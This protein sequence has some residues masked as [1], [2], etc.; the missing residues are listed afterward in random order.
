MR[1]FF[2]FALLMAFVNYGCGGLDDDIS[3]SSNIVNQKGYSQTLITNKVC[4]NR[5]I[6][7]L[8]KQFHYPRSSF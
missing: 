4:E 8:K 2:K 5:E 7:Y 6:N 3:M 1:I